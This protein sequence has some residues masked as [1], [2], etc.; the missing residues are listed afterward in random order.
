MDSHRLQNT[1]HLILL[2]LYM[3]IFL[4]TILYISEEQELHHPYVEYLP[5]LLAQS[6]IHLERNKVSGEN[7]AF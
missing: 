3:Q 1:A 4:S 2:L 6:Y 5:P 7:E